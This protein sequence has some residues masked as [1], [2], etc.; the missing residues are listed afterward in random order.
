MKSITVKINDKTVVIKKL[1]LGRFA[2]VLAA[3]DK[4]PGYLSSFDELSVEKIILELP[5]MI[6]GAFPELLEVLSIA[7]GVPRE[8][9]DEEYGLDDVTFLLKGIFEVNNFDLVIKNI[10]GLLPKKPKV[11]PTPEKPVAKTGSKR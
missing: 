7:S 4:L 5:E 8:E 11:A 1:P 9:L 3:L 2:K 10:K 6:S